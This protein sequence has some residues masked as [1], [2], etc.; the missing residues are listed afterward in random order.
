[1]GINLRFRSRCL[2]ES[3]IQLISQNINSFHLTCFHEL[4]RLESVMYN[5]IHDQHSAVFHWTENR[6]FR[7]GKNSEIIPSKIDY[8]HLWC[9]NWLTT[10]A[11]AEEKRCRS[12][13]APWPNNGTPAIEDSSQGI[14]GMFFGGRQIAVGIWKCAGKQSRGAA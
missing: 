4:R 8:G 7:G 5:T 2:P 9:V 3:A 12:H 10:S 11:N 1:M 14:S 6:D 13:N